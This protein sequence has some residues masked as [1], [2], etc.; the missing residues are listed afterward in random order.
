M[1]DMKEIIAIIRTD[2]VESTKKALESVGVKGITFSDV[3]GRG[4]QR[5]TIQTLDPEASIRRRAGGYMLQ[6]RGMITDEEY[7]RYTLPVEKEIDLGFL[8]KKMLV[9]ITGDDE[10]P[11]IVQTLIRANQKGQHGD[12]RIFVCPL[13]DSIRI[14]TGEHGDPAL[15]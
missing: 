15:S 14:R 4:R 12:G 10:V 6:Q 7:P 5:G 3:I 9:M 2:A 13:E 11:L 1:S 8:P